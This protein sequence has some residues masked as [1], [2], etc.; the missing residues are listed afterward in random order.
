MKILTLCL[1][2]LLVLSCGRSSTKKKDGQDDSTTVPGLTIES[3]ISEFNY[4]ND[5]QLE[6]SGVLLADMSSSAELVTPYGSILR[7]RTLNLLTIE[8]KEF[9]V[10]GEDGVFATECEPNVDYPDHGPNHPLCEVAHGESFDKIIICVSTNQSTSL[11]TAQNWPGYPTAVTDSTLG[12]SC[13][14]NGVKM[15]SDNIFTY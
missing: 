9:L 5:N 8:G 1:I 3:L 14:V 11:M 12:M 6:Y 2:S 7:G 10:Y 15:L 13:W 4:P